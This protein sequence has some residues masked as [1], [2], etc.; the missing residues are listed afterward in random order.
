ML[1]IDPRGIHRLEDVRM[2]TKRA[3]ITGLTWMR[4]ATHR[5]G[6]AAFVMLLMTFTPSAAHAQPTITNIG[7][8]PG[9]SVSQ[10]FGLSGDGS[11]VAGVASDPFT[12]DRAV[13]WTAAG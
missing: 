8:L 11:V 5:A 4:F 13:R 7:I 6:I 1:L 10:A 12:S 2:R 9:G 3:V